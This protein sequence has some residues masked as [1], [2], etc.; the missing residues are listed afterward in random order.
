LLLLVSIKASCRRPDIPSVFDPACKRND[1]VD[2]RHRLATHADQAALRLAPCSP[3]RFYRTDAAARP[4]FAIPP[5][6]VVLTDPL[7]ITICVICVT[8]L[9]I[10]KGGFAGVGM[11]A[12]PL[13]ALI[14]PPLQAAAIFLP[15]LLVQDAISVWAYRHD[16]DAWNLKV[17]LPGAIVG[18]AVA[19]V[20][21]AY[22]PDAMVRLLV[23]VIGLAFVLNAW[24]GRIPPKAP[25]P[26]ALS[27]AFWGSLSGFT[28]TLI[29]AGS[30]PFQV[31]VLPQRLPKLTFVGT[32]AIFFAAINVFK[33]AP[34]A[35]L[36]Q[37]STSTLKISLVMLPLAIASNFLGIW[38]VRVTPVAPF[39]RIAYMLVFLISLGLT[40]QAL[41]T[42]FFV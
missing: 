6:P 16:W 14:V 3:L 17:M 8:I 27:G 29:Q 21:A 31:H 42:L 26:S 37:F 20:F 33:L 13:M 28:S 39:Y 11:V 34:Y 25:R 9:G 1:I 36:H 19:W 12:T 24:L 41:R 38:L 18:I 7:F 22:L 2:Y 10:A 23:G 35:Q 40:G 30:P 4:I 32:N 15:I 5:D